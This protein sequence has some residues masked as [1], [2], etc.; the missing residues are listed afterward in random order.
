[1]HFFSYASFN[2]A[3]T[4]LFIIIPPESS[5]FLAF[6]FNLNKISKNW[7]VDVDVDFAFHEVTRFVEGVLSLHL[8]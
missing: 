3:I 6:D 8:D 5:L 2:L 7:G 1:V 4:F